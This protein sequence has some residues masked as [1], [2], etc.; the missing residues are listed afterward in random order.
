MKKISALIAVLLAGGTWAATPPHRRV[1]KPLVCDFDPDRNSDPE[2]SLLE[3]GGD[4]FVYTDGVSK[5][6]AAGKPGSL[7][8]FKNALN[9]QD[10]LVREM[11]IRSLFENTRGG[12]EESPALDLDNST[13]IYSFETLDIRFVTSK[14]PGPLSPSVN[15]PL[16]EVKMY[17]GDNPVIYYFENA[18]TYQGKPLVRIVGIVNDG[19][20]EYCHPD[21]YHR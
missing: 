12:R 18:A 2:T 6:K 19:D 9:R 13:E 17:V 8:H 14:R 1:V 4:V 11:V 10:A 16:F 5:F 3:F 7:A 15:P 21:F 20:L